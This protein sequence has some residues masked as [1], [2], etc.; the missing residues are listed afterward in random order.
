[1]SKPSTSGSRLW[2]KCFDSLRLWWRRSRSCVMSEKA[3]EGALKEEMLFTPNDWTRFCLDGVMKKAETKMKPAALLVD[4]VWRLPTWSKYV[5]VSVSLPRVVGSRNII[6][7]QLR[8]R[9]RP[10]PR[11]RPAQDRVALGGVLMFDTKGY[12][13]MFRKWCVLWDKGT[14]QPSTGRQILVTPH[15]KFSS[16]CEK[17]L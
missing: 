13:D 4:V 12:G 1:M 6:F 17:K 9:S 10:Q 5:R 3:W 15:Q 16:P 2:S 8:E 11:I 7:L 14:R